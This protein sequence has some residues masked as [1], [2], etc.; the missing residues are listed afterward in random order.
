M[1]A[2]LSEGIALQ[3]FLLIAKSA[4]GKGCT[5]V[6]DQVLQAPG[7]FVFGE[8][9]DMPNVKQVLVNHHFTIVNY[10]LT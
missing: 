7:I 6:I 1:S 4:K 10:F 5:A 3:P 2:E 9:L 8:L